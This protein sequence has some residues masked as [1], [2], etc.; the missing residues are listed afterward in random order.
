[1]K[2]K[3]T[4]FRALYKKFTC[5][6][7]EAAKWLAMDFPGADEANCILTYGYIDW[8]AGLSLEILAC[9]ESKGGKSRFFETRNDIRAYI[10][11]GSVVDTEFAIIDPNGSSLYEKYKESYE[12]T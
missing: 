1:M 5:F 12:R 9:G 7:I 6:P 8:E 4:G 2:Y 10:R 11:I 3:D